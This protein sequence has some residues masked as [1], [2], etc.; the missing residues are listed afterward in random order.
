MHNGESRLKY[1]LLSSIISHLLKQR[2]PSV[3]FNETD[4]L[5]ELRDDPKSFILVLYLITGEMLIEYSH[6][7]WKHT[8]VLYTTKTPTLP[9]ILMPQYE[10]NVCTLQENNE[11][12]DSDSE[13]RCQT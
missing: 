11:K 10:H 7:S 4:V 9:F 5:N 3:H 13:E 1:S 12:E 2:L 6:A 8:K